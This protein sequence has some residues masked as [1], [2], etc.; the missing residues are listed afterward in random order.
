MRRAASCRRRN[1][2]HA[3]RSFPPVPVDPHPCITRTTRISACLA[4][5]MSASRRT[6]ASVVLGRP[7]STLI[8]RIFS[9]GPTGRLVCWCVPQNRQVVAMSGISL[10][11]VSQS[12]ISGERR[13]SADSR[14]VARL[15]LCTRRAAG[16]LYAG[17]D[18]STSSIFRSESSCK[19]L[20]PFLWNLS[21]DQHGL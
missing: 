20:N 19:F 5:V 12:F 10:P 17:G 13:A 7:I 11:H 6:S 9:R 2:R 15:V 18:C 3:S 21:R 14:T 4:R 1:A 8:E 16:R